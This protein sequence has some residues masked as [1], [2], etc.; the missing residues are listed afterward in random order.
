VKNR[1]WPGPVIVGALLRVAAWASGLWS[2]GWVQTDTPQYWA[3]ASNGLAAYHAREGWLYGLALMRPPGYPAILAAMRLVYDDYAGAAFLQVG[4]GL[5]AIVLTYSLARRVADPAVAAVA[6]WWVALS[7]LHVVES[8]VLLTEV[9]FSVFLLAAAFVVAP[10]AEVEPLEWWR[11]GAA[12]LLLGLAILIRPIAL[13][14]PPVVLLVMASISST[15]RLR[16]IAAGLALVAGA[17]VP[18]GSWMAR[19]HRVTGVATVSTIEGINL[20]FYRAAGAIAV[21]DRIPL[22]E[23]QERV[24]ALVAAETD[25]DMNP[26]QVARVETRVGVR[27]ILRHPLGYA[28][29]ALRGLALTLFGPARSHFVERFHATPLEL[30]TRQLIALSALSAALLSILSL[31]GTTL[32]LRARRWR[33]LLVVGLPVLYLLAIGSGQEAWARFRVA[34][35]PFLVILAAPALLRWVRLRPGRD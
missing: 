20:A 27:E 4:F 28:W 6:A 31:A 32:W 34:L 8:S 5:A 13:Y 18:V 2:G 19:N 3:L 35:E 9:P 21:E 30:A 22:D 24:A 14:L 11:W 16:M 7:P 1:G 10:R 29:T 15:R 25:P 26:A 12:G 23:A 33:P 17:A